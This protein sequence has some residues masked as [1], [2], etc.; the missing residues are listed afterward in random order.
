MSVFRVPSGFEAK[1]EQYYHT[2]TVT[3]S[4]PDKTKTGLQDV[5]DDTIYA[6]KQKTL[7]FVDNPIL[8]DV[9]AAENC[10]LKKIMAANPDVS[11]L[12]LI[13]DDSA[14][15]ELRNTVSLEDFIPPQQYTD[16]FDLQDF[17]DDAKAK[18][19]MMPASF[20]KIYNNN[21]MELFS[22][23]K[24]NQPLVAENFYKTLQEKP[25][26]TR[27][28]SGGTPAVGV[29]KSDS[30]NQQSNTNSNSKENNN[31]K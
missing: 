29:S 30:D 9:T 13:F 1:N 6:N 31:D 10:D 5:P 14:L 20:R 15:D 27:S 2:Y 18:F 25:P 22:A 4:P 19:Y 3:C 28:D 11:G 16:I 12:S 26:E 23:M 7:K 8:T 17:I 21:V 24:T